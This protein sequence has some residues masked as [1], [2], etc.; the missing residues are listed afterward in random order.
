[1]WRNNII[2]N[3]ITIIM[4]RLILLFFL[5]VCVS[6]VFAQSG[7]DGIVSYVDSVS[8]NARKSIVN[9]SSDKQRRLSESA[10]G[11]TLY[12]REGK[13]IVKYEDDGWMS[14]DILHCMQMAIDTWESK[15]DI[16][17]PFSFGFSISEDLSP[18]VEILTDVYYSRGNREAV[19]TSLYYQNSKQGSPDSEV[20]RIVLNVDV[21]WNSSW[22]Y[23]NSIGYDNLTTALLRHVAHILGFGIT[24]VERDG[25]WGFT[26][27]SRL[28]SAYDRLVSNGQKTLASLANH[29][30]EEF[31]EF[32]KGKLFLKFSD[33][34]YPLYSSS[35]GYVSYRTGNYFALN[36]D[37]LMNYPY[38]NRTRLFTI[39]NETLDVMEAIG[40][41]VVSH[42]IE[43][44]A[45]D[46]DMT[47]YGSVYLPHTFSAID[48]NGKTIANASWTYQ[49]YDGENY[50]D[51]M[52][53]QGAEFYISPEVGDDIYNDV[54]MC[55]QARIVCS[56]TS[57]GKTKR[58]YYPVYWEL[59]PHIIGYEVYNVVSDLANNNYC[60]YD[61]K[62]CHSGTDNGYVFVCNDGGQTVNYRVGNES[63]SIIH[64][65]KAH[66]TKTSYIDITL[67]NKYGSTIKLYFFEKKL[68]T[69]GGDV[70]IINDITPDSDEYAY[71]VYTFQG[72]KLGHIINLSEL[73]KGSYIIKSTLST[74]K[75]KKYMVR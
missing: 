23:D 43:I 4:K 42:D 10:V 66:K 19:P 44:V 14:E 63:E 39:N 25:G 64:V 34:D 21:D 36:W 22:A 65:S 61:V 6:S 20:G 16:Q 45:T 11:E 50:I 40:W 55:Q 59:R 17:I 60:S 15:I 58:Y 51:R 70:N 28:P 27:A 13:I 47:G 33:A 38:G 46:A 12:S 3:M 57:N 71:E 31:E 41:N 37:N 75:I 18:D 48:K 73:P 62:L 9:R 69:V 2:N 32:F 52:S 72:V 53:T 74:W 68:K 26:V 56:V 5:A 7:V 24:A 1:M 49:L 8:S 67:E 29:S 35:E 30:N 54:F